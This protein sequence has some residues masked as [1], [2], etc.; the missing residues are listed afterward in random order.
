METISKLALYTT[1][2]SASTF[3]GIVGLKTAAAAAIPTI[4]SCTGTVISGVGTIHG[5]ATAAI[6]AFS[7]GPVSITAVVIGGIV[8][9]CVFLVHSLKTTSNGVQKQ[10]CN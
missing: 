1:A 2:G 9:G 7:A 5:P 8:V 4:M 10:C 3:I 6:A